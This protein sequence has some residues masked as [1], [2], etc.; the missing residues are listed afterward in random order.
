M[1]V[2]QLVRT[3]AAWGERPLL[4]TP[5]ERLSYRVADER[6][7]VLARCLLAAGVGKNTRVAMVL[8][9][10]SDWVVTFLALARV[11]AHAV[12]LNPFATAAE[13]AYALGHSD[14]HAVVTGAQ[15]GGVPIADLLVAT[16]AGLGAHRAPDPI[17]AVSHPYLRDAWWLGDG[18]PA[19]ARDPERAPTVRPEILG[20]VEAQVFPSDP[21]LTTYTSGTTA[22]PK[23]VMHS[24]GA[25]LRQAE[26]L[27]ARRWLTADSVL[28]TPMPLFWVGGVCFSLLSCAASGMPMV[29]DARFDAGRTLDLLEQER[30]THVYCWP[31]AAESLVTHPS[32]P[33]R[34]ITGLRAGP[35][36]LRGPEFAGV[37]IDQREQSL[38]MTETCGPHTFSFDADAILPE[39]LRGSFG[40]PVESMEHRIVDRETLEPLPD[41]EIG[42]LLVR[43]EGLMLGFHKRERQD[44]FL[45]DGWYRTGD[46]CSWHDGRLFFHGRGGDMIKTAG[47]NVAPAEVERVIEEIPGVMHVVVLALDHPVR[48]QE[49]GAL[50]A[51]RPGS[52]ATAESLAARVREQLSSYKVPTVWCLVDEATYPMGVT[53]KVER[54]R[55][56]ALLEAA[57]AERRVQ[58]PSDGDRH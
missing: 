15:A 16:V 57:Q 1:T 37:A 25:I 24:Q 26:K 13:L 11:G 23:A 31:K 36:Q 47:F 10:G 27:A 51:L 3:F 17:L 44:T 41:Y 7:A 38:G 46:L 49:I 33:D 21:I 14:A 30:V 9:N 5:D 35:S 29:T 8:A 6:S 56:R 54:A 45:P 4:I 39:H 40:P 19:W 55:A 53:G 52:D 20:A 12:L 42:E 18:R 32:W 22:E 2:P 50:V 58:E 34:V 43:G 28:Y 48:D